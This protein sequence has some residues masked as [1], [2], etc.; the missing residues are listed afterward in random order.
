MAEGAFFPHGSTVS[1]AGT[2]V[3]GL[4]DIPLPTYSKE[5]VETT[6]HGDFVRTYVGGLADAGSI[7]IPM[8]LIPGDAG[9]Q[10]LVDNLEADGNTV[11]EVVITTP[12][13]IDPQVSWTFDAYVSGITGNLPWEGSAAGMEVTFRVVSKP[14][15]D[16][17]TIYGS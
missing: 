5:E 17:T 8:R 4:L 2:P 12:D 1:F 9:Q 7:T 16:V 10:A 3:G 13:V 11:E 14:V 6:A 15:R